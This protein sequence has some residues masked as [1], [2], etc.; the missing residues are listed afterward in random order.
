MGLHLCLHIPIAS[1][2]AACKCRCDC[3]QACL[4]VLKCSFLISI[5]CSFCHSTCACAFSQ[6]PML[7]CRTTWCF[8]DGFQ[9]SCTHIP[10]PVCTSR[11]GTVC[12]LAETSGDGSGH[13]T[14]VRRC[15]RQQHMMW[16]RGSWRQSRWR[17]VAAVAR[18][19]CCVR[20]QGQRH[21]APRMPGTMRLCC[22]GAGCVPV[23]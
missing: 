15:Q 20:S 4:G 7:V 17:Q 22:T 10:M 6:S 11:H 18:L 9:T 12:C 19:Q 23:G 14:G 21:P 3:L 8:P 13:G 5:I 2:V 1:L 16:W